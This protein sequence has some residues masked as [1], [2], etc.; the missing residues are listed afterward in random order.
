MNE[1]HPVEGLTS[2]TVISPAPLPEVKKQLKQSLI[3]FVAFIREQG[4]VGL[5]IAFV[6]GGAVNKVVSSLVVDIIQPIIGLIFGSTK[7][8]MSLHVGPVMIGNF[9][10]TTIDFAIIAWVVYF[11]FKKLKL[12]Q[13]DKKKG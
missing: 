4:V 3:E 1:I 13:L 8:L 10:A 11:I 5:A 12:E 7:G 9:L 2:P 6:L